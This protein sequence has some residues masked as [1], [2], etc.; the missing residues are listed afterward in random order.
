MASSYPQET[1]GTTLLSVDHEGESRRVFVVERRGYIEVGEFTRGPLTRELYDDPA[2]YHAIHVDVDAPVLY[3]GFFMEGEPFLADL[4]DAYDAQGVSYGYL[5]TTA[6]HHASFR[7]P[8][9]PLFSAR[10]PYCAQF[11]RTP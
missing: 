6:N 9:E 1:L 7:P 8:R 2:H 11:V 10:T 3:K 4:M 5:N